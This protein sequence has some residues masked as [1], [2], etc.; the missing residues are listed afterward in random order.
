MKSKFEEGVSGSK[1]AYFLE[2]VRST[3]LKMQINL[4]KVKFWNCPDFS[5]TELAHCHI[6][7]FVICI[8]ED[9]LNACSNDDLYEI[10][11]HEVTHLLHGEHNSDFYATL[12][13]F[14]SANWKPT[15]GSIISEKD[16]SDHVSNKS[17]YKDNKKKCAY[18]LGL[19][20][21]KKL[22]FC[23]YC[24]RKFCKYHLVPRPIKNSLLNLEIPLKL[25]KEL[26]LELAHPCPEYT[27]FFTNK[28]HKMKE[29][30]INRMN[31]FLNSSKKKV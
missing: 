16:L 10:A 4:P 8:S 15:G 25:E 13:Y 26:S 9:T 11:V 27:L 29:K 14:K 6:D 30:E 24:N 7:K 5:G 23:K 19:N 31:S 12:N 21:T 28:V 3:A 18:Q 2:V 1:K 17:N 22:V 20:H